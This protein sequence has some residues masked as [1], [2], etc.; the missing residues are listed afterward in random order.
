MKGNGELYKLFF[1]LQNF[2]KPDF[3]I[4]VGA[5][6]AEFSFAMANKFGTKAVAFEANPK[7]FKVYTEETSI[8]EFYKNIN[9]YKNTQMVDYLN[10]AISD[11]TGDTMINAHKRGMVANSS[12]KT[13]V[14]GNIIESLPVRCT[15]LDEYF[16]NIEFSNAALWIDAEGSNGEILQGAVETLKKCS[17]I[18]I[19][20]EDGLFWHNAWQTSDVKNFLKQNGFNKIAEEDIYVEQKN[21]IFIKEIK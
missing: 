4:E 21:H 6:K 14:N 5:Y 12:L 8:Y 20:T 13:I 11:Y 2:L 10:I 16:K 17:S 7:V 9:S 1:E 15:T 3:V 19:E 18:F